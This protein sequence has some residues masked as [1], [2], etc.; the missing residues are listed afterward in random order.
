MAST[1]HVEDFTLIEAEALDDVVE[2]M[3]MDGLL[4][5]LAE[6]ILSED[7]KGEEAQVAQDD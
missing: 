1:V 5:R 6:Q 2:G 3:G 4:E 7:S